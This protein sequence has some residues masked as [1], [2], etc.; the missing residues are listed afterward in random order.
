[1]K[2][3][4]LIIGPNY[5]NFLTAAAHSCEELGY[6]IQVLPY[7]NPI[8]P[9]TTLMKWRYRFG[10]KEKLRSESRA[11]FAQTVLS[12]FKNFSPDI[13]F[14]MNGE[15]L[16]AAILD[17][18]RKTAKVAVWFF[19]NREKLPCA[20]NHVDHCDAL[21][22]FDRGDVEWYR[23]KGKAA[24]FL[25]QACDCEIYF[26]LKEER[27]IDILFI[28]DLFYSQ[29]RKDIMNAVIGHYPKRD[30]VVYGS[31]QPW[32]KGLWKWICRPHKGIYRNM[33]VTG[34]EA[35]FLYNK[36]N[37]VLNIHRESQMDGANP[38]FFEICGSGAYQICDRNSYTASVFPEGTVGLYSDMDELFALIDFALHNNMEEQARKAREELLSKHTFTRRM[39]EALKVVLNEVPDCQ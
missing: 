4:I 34:A 8:H 23:S 25:P 28:G 29:R 21:F 22:C 32:Y 37:I 14:I 12:T 5:F 24:Y 1:M 30:I 31:Y 38:R 9:Y 20:E 11:F 15:I 7:D 6:E 35:N 39:E 36:A 16:D 18:L 13:V 27:D 19:D 26:P 3:K 33:N 2:G 10:N 17:F